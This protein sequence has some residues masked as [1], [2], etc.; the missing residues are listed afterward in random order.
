MTGIYCFEMFTAAYLWFD[1]DP[2]V[3]CLLICVLLTP[4][5]AIIG[6]L[7][8]KILH[9]AHTILGPWCVF[10]CLK[11][12]CFALLRYGL[13]LSMFQE[14]WRH[15]SKSNGNWNPQIHNYAF[16]VLINVFI[17]TR[18][19]TKLRVKH[20]GKAELVEHGKLKWMA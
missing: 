15:H 13:N 1:E 17:S 12:F 2:E 14:N 20:S 7:Y 19:F 5:L 9:S 8:K 11:T 18:A 10:A 6:L 16:F 4:K 3:D